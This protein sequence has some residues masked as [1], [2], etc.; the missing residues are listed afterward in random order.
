MRHSSH[1]QDKTYLRDDQYKDSSNL[2][3]RAALHR[4]F[5]TATVPWQVWVFDQLDIQPGSRILECGCGPGWLWRENIARIPARCQITLTDLSPGMI[6]EA[7]AALKNTGHDFRFQVV[8]IEEIPFDEASFDVII[9]NH[10]LYH[11]PNRPQ[12]L[13]EVRRVLRPN[14]RFFA[15][16]N[17]QNHMREFWQIGQKLLADDDQTYQEEFMHPPFRLENGRQQLEPYFDQVTVVLYEDS[18]EVTEAEPLLAYAL[19]SSR[20]AVEISAAMKEKARRFL[21]EMIAE[22]GAIHITKETCLFIAT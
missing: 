17:G 20:L 6:A 2:D 1:F 7:E 10:M 19:S 11:V 3:V 16:T 12:A 18:L 13:S 21:T 14:G 5:S 8:N 4:R 22:Q 9:A 15:A